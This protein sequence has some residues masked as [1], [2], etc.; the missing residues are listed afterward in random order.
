MVR[1]LLLGL[2]STLIFI[3]FYTGFNDPELTDVRH[4]FF[5]TITTFIIYAYQI[6]RNETLSRGARWRWY[7]WLFCGFSLSLQ[8]LHSS[9]GLSISTPKKTFEILFINKYY[10]RYIIFYEILFCKKYPAP[11]LNSI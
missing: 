6:S 7:L 4:L 1:Y 9:I 2:P 11:Y 10:N 5:F 8:S 3:I